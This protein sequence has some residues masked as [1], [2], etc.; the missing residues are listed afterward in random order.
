ML[1]I[2]IIQVSVW[3]TM[4]QWEIKSLL[5]L[6]AIDRSVKLATFKKLKTIIVMN[7]SFFLSTFFFNKFIIFTHEFHHHVHFDHDQ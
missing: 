5:D 4:L 6:D 2:L 3:E 7:F 1:K